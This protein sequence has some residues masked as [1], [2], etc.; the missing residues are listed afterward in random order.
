MGV[1]GQFAFAQCSLCA[2]PL[3]RPNARR[4]GPADHGLLSGAVPVN[5]IAQVYGYAVCLVAVIVFV[6]NIGGLANSVISLGDPLHA[7]IR[8]RGY[9]DRELSSFEVYRIDQEQSAQRLARQ[10]VPP[11]PV[12]LP[13]D[14]VLL[15]QYE[16]LRSSRESDIRGDARRQL[17]ESSTLLIVAVLLFATHWRWVRRRESA[18]DQPRA[19]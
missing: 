8:L 16:S 13:P 10:S 2:N 3:G 5:R 9:E 17:A 4:G 18:G 1:V 7:D 15:R 6:T 12:A 14:S 11:S 19:A